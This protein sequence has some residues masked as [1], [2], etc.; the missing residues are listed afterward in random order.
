M[1]TFEKLGTASDEDLSN[2]MS[3]SLDVGSTSTQKNMRWESGNVVL[4]SFEI[5]LKV[6]ETKKPR[7]QETKKQ[8]T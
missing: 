7:H 8:E 2:K 5:I 1:E 6:F 4:I 3:K